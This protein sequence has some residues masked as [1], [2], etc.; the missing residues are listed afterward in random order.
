MT[1]TAPGS[2]SAS[3]AERGDNVPRQ[4]CSSCRAFESRRH[5][6]LT[7]SRLSS[8]DATRRPGERGMD[9]T[10]R[11]RVSS[12][13]ASETKASE[14]RR[15]EPGAK[16]R[17]DED[18]TRLTLDAQVSGL[19][20]WSVDARGRKRRHELV[21]ALEAGASESLLACF[22]SFA[23]TRRATNRRA[24]VSALPSFPVPSTYFL[25]PPSSPWISSGTDTTPL[26]LLHDLHPNLRGRL[27]CRV[28]D[29]Y[30]G[31]ETWTRRRWC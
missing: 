15:A 6:V 2:G 5:R 18:S 4:K 13:D 8:G 23:S 19:R 1:T 29:A 14:C 30:W 9:V 31:G 21:D 28:E 20:G 22:D 12:P 17:F 11:E 7:R 25:L 16:N 26:G 3:S 27:Q 10:R 24:R